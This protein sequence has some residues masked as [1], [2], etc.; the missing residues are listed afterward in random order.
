MVPRPCCCSPSC[1]GHLASFSSGV[2][3]PQSRAVQP[4]REASGTRSFLRGL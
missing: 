1:P 3:Q 4:E 2:H